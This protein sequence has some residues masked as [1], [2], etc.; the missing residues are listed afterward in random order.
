MKEA[1]KKIEINNLSIIQGYFLES[2]LE[3]FIP[4]QKH[5]LEV[6]FSACSQDFVRTLLRRRLI[7]GRELPLS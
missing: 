6:K 4:Y 5:K 7:Y 2:H 3:E 1:S